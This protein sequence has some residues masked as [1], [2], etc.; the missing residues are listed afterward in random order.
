MVTAFATAALALTAC[1]GQPSAAPVTVTETVVGTTTA[2]PTTTVPTATT[3]PSTPRTTS[4]R[5]NLVKKVGELGAAGDSNGDRSFEFTVTE[6]DT[7]VK[8]GNPYARKPEGK[9][10]AIKITAKTTKNVSLDTLGSDEIWFTQD[11]KAID[12]NGETAG[13]DPDSTDAVYNCEV[14]PSLMRGV[15]PSEKIT[16]WVVLD[17]PDLE[18]VI[19]WQPGFMVNGG[20]EWQL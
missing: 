16:G 13:W 8:C 14:K 6:V 10:I 1:S 9:L 5:G 20:W 17:V 7:S 15:G 4:D 11:W 3:P 18:S 12:K 19:V 2:A